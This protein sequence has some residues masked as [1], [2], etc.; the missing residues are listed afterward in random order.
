MTTSRLT[1]VGTTEASE[2]VRANARTPESAVAGT[3]W[4]PA[5]VGK[6][7]DD[8]ICVALTAAGERCKR[9]VSKQVGAQKRCF[10]HAK[11]KGKKMQGKPAPK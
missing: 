10:G 8:G 11:F 2:G 4:S 1:Q 5:F 9:E 7:P 3:A 6:V